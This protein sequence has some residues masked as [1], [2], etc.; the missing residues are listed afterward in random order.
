MV[1]LCV[2]FFAELPDIARDPA[3]HFDCVRVGNWSDD[4][5]IDRALS[6]FPEKTV[7][8]HHNGNLR[9]DG[10]QSKEVFTTLCERQ[11]RTGS[12]W[13][14]AHL[15][16]HT[17]EEI[18]AVL[19]DGVRPPP[20][21]PEEAVELV[22]EG[23][24]ALQAQLPVPLLLENLPHW[25]LAEPD[26]AVTPDFI[27]RVLKGSA[28]GFL[29]DLPHACVTADVLG[30]P[31]EVYLEALPLDK[32]VEVHVSGPRQRN[33]RLA[34]AHE[35]LREADYA[36]LQWVLQRTAPKAVTLEYWK[37]PALVRDQIL[38]LGEL[39]ATHSTS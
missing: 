15:D 34:D 22:R 36:L 23:A 11:R 33:G 26:L 35:P 9:P 12:P 8:Y 3:V 27:R 16:H 31:V 5:T 4:R 39:L 38:R 24:R 6:C 28:H 21:D 37:D 20:Y 14:S 25:P 1:E 18:R 2:S 32:V 29:I 7:L 30:M 19:H 10:P 17:D 13:L